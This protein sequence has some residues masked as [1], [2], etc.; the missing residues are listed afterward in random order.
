MPQR[1]HRSEPSLKEILDEPIV[2][3]LMERDGVRRVDVERIVTGLDRRFLSRRRQCAGR[4]ATGA[5]AAD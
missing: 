2:R 3:M 1:A 4:E 5:D